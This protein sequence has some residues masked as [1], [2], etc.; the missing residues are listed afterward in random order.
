VRKSQVPPAAD[1]TASWIWNHAIYQSFSAEDSGVL[2]IRGKPGS[3]K[4][5]LA[6]SIQRRLLEASAMKEL[7]I[8]PT[9]VGD[10]FYHR[11]RGGGYVRHESFVRSVLFHFL[12]QRPLLFDE[13]FQN[14]YRAMDPRKAVPWTYDLLVDIF[15]AICQSTVRV[16]C[17][18]D[19]VDEAESTEIVSLIKTVVNPESRSKAKFIILSRPHVQIERE[20]EAESTIVVENENANDIKKIIDHGLSS[21]QKSLHSLDFARSAPPSGRPNRV[22]RRPKT[23]QPRFRSLATTVGREH[24]A[25]SEIRD[26]MIAKAQGSILWVKLILDE[27]RTEAEGNEG[28][29]IEELRGIVNQVPEQLSDYYRHIVDELTDKKQP[30]RIREIRQALMW[31]CAAPEIG[32]I[33]LDGLW[34]ALAMLKD[35]FKA[36]TLDDIWQKQILINSYDELWRKISSICGP[37][38][39]IFNPGLSAEESRIYNY[40]PS[41]IVQLMHQSVRDFLCDPE[42]SG[43]LHFA[44]DEARELVRDH[45]ENYLDLTMSDYHCMK[46]EP[47]QDPQLVV[48]WLNDQKILRLAIKAGKTRIRTQKESMRITREWTLEEAPKGSPEDLVI[49]ALGD[50]SR[51]AENMDDEHVRQTTMAIGQ[52]LYHACIDGLVTAARN[53]LA[54]G[55]V[56]PDEAGSGHGQII[57]C[58]L[59]FAASRFES[60]RVKAELDLSWNR[61]PAFLTDPQNDRPTVPRAWVQHSKP[62]VPSRLRYCISSSDL[63]FQVDC[64]DSLP[65]AEKRDVISA[66]YGIASDV[67]HLPKSS[68][69]GRATDSDE[70]QRPGAER[71]VPPLLFPIEQR[72]DNERSSQAEQGS[73]KRSRTGRAVSGARPDPEV[74]HGA[75]LE[76]MNESEASFEASSTK[77]KAKASSESQGDSSDGSHSG[78]ELTPTLLG[79]AWKNQ[80]TNEPSSESGENRDAPV[81]SPKMKNR[82]TEADWV[83]WPWTVTLKISKD[84]T[85]FEHRITFG[86]WFPFLDIICGSKRMKIEQREVSECGEEEEE[87]EDQVG[88]QMVAP[89][90]DV[91]DAIIEALGLYRQVGH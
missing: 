44:L 74:P 38:I 7:H 26:T 88:E 72:R 32:D 89:I 13:V 22:P 11:R 67:E 41:S 42:M 12:Q 4:S 85:K 52:I 53:I 9:L 46:L 6:R 55:W 90:E 1:G 76:F 33:T 2:W 82:S 59:L 5:V 15:T 34:E 19:A 70:L 8:N 69:E 66:S 16:V 20:I 45:L 39:E 77:S 36:N 49:S 56:T 71:L 81:G 31:I 79:T 58:H 50:Y 84:D 62:M 64:E 29:T 37:F 51:H 30:K 83:Q 86:E 68:D 65:K 80:N 23:R 21:L 57:M 91:E 47:R 48:N 25:I 14:I 17:I 75:E 73:E 61:E 18:V 40:G 87:E 60:S 63:P 10:W 78:S 28:S 27:L 43:S 3:G 24:Q 54:L 35:D